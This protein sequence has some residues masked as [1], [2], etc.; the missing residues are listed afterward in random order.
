MATR[1]LAP[2]NAAWL[3]IDT[4]KTPM[5]A[6]GLFIF[7]HPD[8]VPDGG[9]ADYLRTLVSDLTRNRELEAPW[10][11]RLRRAG[12]R[13]LPIMVDDERADLE[14]HIR[15]SAL[16]EP[17]GERELGELISR[18]HSHRLDLDRPLWECHVIGGLEGGR[19]AIYVKIHQVLTYGPMGV[20]TLLSTLSEDP[21]QRGISPLWGSG[22]PS[23]QGGGALD[24][25]KMLSGVAGAARS[26][27]DQLSLDS[28][29]KVVTRSAPKSMLTGRIG[30]HRRVA[31]QLY[32]H[33]AF[34]ALC[35]EAQ[36]D[37]AVLVQYLVG[38]ALRRYLKEY[39]ALPDKSLVAGFPI[40]VDEDIGEEAG[41]PGVAIGMARLGT[42]ISDHLSRLDMIKEG[43]ARARQ[44]VYGLSAEGATLYT[45][46]L[47]QPYMTS[48]M[49]RTITGVTK[50]RVPWNLFISSYDGPQGPLYF[51]G[52]PLEA[53]HP[54]PPLWQG[55]GLAISSLSANGK[56]SMGVI[57]DRDRVPHT[58]RL[59]VYMG[60]ALEDLTDRL[61]GAGKEAAQ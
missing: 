33:A 13:G 56:V 21:Y 48:A 47:M 61:I 43:V 46:A 4:P 26:L 53:Y 11:Q 17:G 49:A 25:A 54:L 22:L 27:F 60:D 58:Q 20:H 55:S 39:N 40:V 35:A 7:N 1:V 5:H 18:L 10:N 24:P 19:F 51:N 36:I 45:L 14:Y 41:D 31:T 59:A 50:V 3:T 15:Y 52:A 9:M 37:H 57:G 12:L 34:D 29:G 28:I 16:P 8:D 44:R 42:D 38:T 32:D 6:G 23:A 2:T 30:G